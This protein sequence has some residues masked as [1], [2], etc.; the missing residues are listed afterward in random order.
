MTHSEDV[1]VGIPEIFDDSVPVI[2]SFHAPKE[3]LVF[4]KTEKGIE[5]VFEVI[6]GD[7]NLDLGVLGQGDHTIWVLYNE[8]LDDGS[9][10]FYNNY[11]N[12]SVGG[13]MI[14]P[15]PLVLDDEDTVR[16]NFGEGAEGSV[17]G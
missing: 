8:T 17:A 12:V 9:I 16:F 15:D 5:K 10:A 2:I 6:N 14:L 3:G 13:W 4:T 7:N 1:E 11:L